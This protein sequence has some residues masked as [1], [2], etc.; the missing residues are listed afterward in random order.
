MGFS[1]LGQACGELEIERNTALVRM[2]AQG[3]A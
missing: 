3:T 1:L 2:K